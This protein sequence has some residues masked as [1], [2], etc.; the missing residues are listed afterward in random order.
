MLGT[1]RPCARFRDLDTLS[2]GTG[3]AAEGAGAHGVQGFLTPWRRT[4]VSSHLFFFPKR[5]N[6]RS[7]AI[8]TDTFT[9]NCK[10]PDSLSISLSGHDLTALS[11]SHVPRPV[12]GPRGP[13]SPHSPPPDARRRVGSQ[14]SAPGGRLP[15]LPAARSR[16]SAAPGAGDR[17]AGWARR[18]VGDLEGAPPRLCLTRPPRGLLR[19]PKGCRS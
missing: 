11:T 14:A 19:D 9:G 7:F 3:E 4:W 10:N 6:E 13:H 16:P 2:R 8:S 18:R 15:A 17:P 12:G 1:S 5:L